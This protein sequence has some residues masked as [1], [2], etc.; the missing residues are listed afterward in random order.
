MSSSPSDIYS[1]SQLFMVPLTL[2]LYSRLP[3]RVLCSLFIVILLQPLG[4]LPGLP[5]CSAFLWQCRRLPMWEL[6]CSTSRYCKLIWGISCPIVTTSHLSS[7][8]PRSLNW[9]T[10]FFETGSHCVTQAGLK[11]GS[12]CFSLPSAG[13]IVMPPYLSHHVC[14]IRHSIKSKMCAP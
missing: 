14:H 1:F 4:T 13:M 3:F 11:L 9:G 6:P 7:A 10:L 2:V 8:H 12:S 5:C